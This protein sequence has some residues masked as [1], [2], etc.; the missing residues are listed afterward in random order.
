MD[1]VPD[2]GRGGEEDE[3]EQGEQGH[4]GAGEPTEGEADEEEDLEYE[5]AE[6]GAESD[7]EV[8]GGRA[9]GDPGADEIGL[10]DAGGGLLEGYAVG[11]NRRGVECCA[12]KS[13]RSGKM[14]GRL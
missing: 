9:D 6:E 3:G 8:A 1:A 12:A 7:D 11:S 10:H 14:A 13:R 5:P 4:D 2:V